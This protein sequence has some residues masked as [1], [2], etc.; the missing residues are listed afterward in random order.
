MAEANAYPFSTGRVDFSLFTA[1]RQLHALLV[2][3]VCVILGGFFVCLHL[4]Q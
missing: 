2:M 4:T 3:T 1:A